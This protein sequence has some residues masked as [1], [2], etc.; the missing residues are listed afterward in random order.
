MIN[1]QKEAN[2]KIPT[3]ITINGKDERSPEVLTESFNNFFKDK[4]KEIEDQFDDNATKAEIFM[5]SLAPKTTSTFS[6]KPHNV[7]KM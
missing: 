2:D 6:F 5:K 7:Y 1:E 3:R 4:I